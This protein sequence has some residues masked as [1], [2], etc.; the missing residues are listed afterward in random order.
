MSL[1]FLDELLWAVGFLL[2]AALLSVLLGKGRYRVL[3][4]FTTWIGF[5][6]LFTVVLFAAQ[7]FG[8]RHLYTICYWA[9]A[10]LDVALQIAVVIEMGRLVLKRSGRW[11]EGA[12][13]RFL[14]MAACGT[15]LAAALAWAVKPYAPTALDLWTI[16]G[17]LFTAMLIC[18]L[19]TAVVAAS[20]QFGLGWRTHVMQEGYG[21]TVW[22][23][24]G[25]IVE[26][27]HGYFG[28][29]RH[30]SSLE[31]T[32][33]MVW[34]GSLLYWTVLFWLPESSRSS[35]TPVQKKQ[36]RGLQKELQFGSPAA[37]RPA[38][39]VFRK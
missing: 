17:N 14:V 8:S 16:R 12:K 28:A 27:L 18:L 2:N 35:P 22:A 13:G 39:G 5:G 10:V 36:Y 19:F 31:H 3:P 37:S 34:F 25:F 7:R 21:L 24:T 9:G 6:I 15:A 1:T 29:V 33:M 11:V 32:R 23:L 20:Q 4:W 38:E 30:F 26:T